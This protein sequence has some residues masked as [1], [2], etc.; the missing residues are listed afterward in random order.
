D[1]RAE[2]WA[3]IVAESGVSQED[4]DALTQVYARGKRVIACWGMGL[5]Q[6]KHSVP[7][8]QILSNLMMMRGNIG[9]PG[10]GLLPVRGHSN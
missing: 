7:T 3:D 4:I 8:V 2:S 10:A 6:H 5:T 1:L 9:R